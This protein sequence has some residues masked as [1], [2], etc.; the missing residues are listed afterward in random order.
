MSDLLQSMKEGSPAE[1][2]PQQ[3]EAGAGTAPPI[4]IGQDLAET[5]GAGGRRYG[6]GNQSAGG[7]VAAG[8]G[9]AIPRVSRGWG[10]SSRGSISTTPAMRLR[11]WW[12]HRGCSA[13]VVSV[14]SFKVDDLYHADR[15]GVEIEKRRGNGFE[16]TNWMEE[17]TGAV[18]GAEAGADRDV[19][20]SGADR[21]RGLR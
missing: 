20:R 3:A 19:Y 4:V 18:P 5:I 10:Y 11:V 1:L 7:D 12:M 21:V 9:A 8:D 17:N 13:N 16:T 2:E 15:I 6:A 14:I